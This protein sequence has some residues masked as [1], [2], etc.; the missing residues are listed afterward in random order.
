MISSQQEVKKRK[1]VTEENI[2]QL[3]LSDTYELV[4]CL[5]EKMQSIEHKILCLDRK[6]GGVSDILDNQFKKSEEEALP[7]SKHDFQRFLDHEIK[8]LLD[9]EIEN[10]V[11]QDLDHLR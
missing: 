7:F 2:L 5:I 1:I 10:I 4:Q 3:K 9:K 6:I 8:D 11:Y